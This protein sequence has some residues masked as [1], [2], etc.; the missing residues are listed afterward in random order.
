MSDRVLAVI[1][2]RGGSKRVPRK[3]IREVGE[4]PLIAYAIDQA[5]AADA[6]D[7]SIVST[8]DDEIKTVA[9]EYG[10]NIPFDRPDH[11][12]TDKATSDE[13]AVHAINWF[14]EKDE[15]F[16]TVCLVPVPA[17]FRNPEDITNSIQRLHET[18]ADS[19]VSVT[20]CDPPAVWAVETDGEYL[21][22][23]FGEEYLWRKTQSQET[24][25]LHYP[26]GAVFAA[27]VPLFLDAETFYTERTVGYEMPRSRSLDIDEPYDLELARALMEHRS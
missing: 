18:E 22:P 9:Q 4:K 3:N 5:K 20:E 7:H 12:A 2:A 11:L 6:V 27:N 26:N 21:T 10:G 23:Y 24:P 15:R 13:V 19:V 8:E 17:P 16:D 25:T 1:P 14:K